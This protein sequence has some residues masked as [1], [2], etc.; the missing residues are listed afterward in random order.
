MNLTLHTDGQIVQTDFV[1]SPGHVGFKDTLHGGILS[2][3]LDEVMSWACA[4]S[5]KRFAYCAELTIRFAR[6]GRPGD[7]M[8]AKAELVANRRGKIFDAKGEIRTRDGALIATGSGKYMPLKESDLAQMA[9]ELMVDP[10][11]LFG[12][13]AS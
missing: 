2:T 7:P 3:V 6:P 11:D 5:T 12:A 13:S 1:L 9:T 8:L 4:V 10:R